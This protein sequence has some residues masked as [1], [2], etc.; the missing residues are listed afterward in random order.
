MADCSFEGCTE[1]VLCKALCRRHYQAKW[2]AEHPGYSSA[3][4][5]KW[6]TENR[7]HVRAYRKRPEEKARRQKLKNEANKRR[8]LRDPEWRER[9]NAKNRDRKRRQGK[10]HL[11]ELSRQWKKTPKG[12]AL[13]RYQTSLYRAALR[14]QM[15]PWTSRQA[16]KD[17]YKHCPAGMHVDHIIPLNNENVCGLH[18]PANLQYLPATD[19]CRKSNLFDPE[20][21]SQLAKL[22]PLS[23]DVLRGFVLDLRKPVA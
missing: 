19:N 16:I 4:A 13:R 22:D 21:I 5:K 7:E 14:S 10:E 11:N 9:L 6:K 8:R 23:L 20:F 3:A 1:P 15:P 18:V 12:R 2:N 17:I